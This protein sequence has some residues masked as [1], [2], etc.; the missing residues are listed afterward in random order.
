MPRTALSLPTGSSPT[1]YGHAGAAR[2]VNMFAEKI[3]PQAKTQTAWWACD[4]LSSFATLTGGGGVRA[5]LALSDSALYVIA[6][7]LVF[8]VDSAGAVTVIGGI[9]TDGFVTMARNRVGQIAIVCDGLYFVIEDEDLTQISDPDLPPPTSVTH[10][11]GYFVYLLEDGRF[12]AS[13]IDATGVDALDTATAEANP[14]GG[15]RAMTRGRDLVLFG[16]RSTEFWGNTGAEFP[17]S[18]TT[19]NDLGCLAAGSVA[20][21]EQTLFWVCHDGTVR[22]LDGYQGRKISSHAVERFI[23]S[24]TDPSALRAT[25]WQSRGH[26]FYALSGAAGTWQYDV[27]TGEWVERQSYGLDRWRVSETIQFGHR[28]IAGN[29]ASGLLYTMS[30]DVYSEA[31]ADMV[32]TIQV[33]PVY[34]DG[35]RVRHNRVEI[36][37][38]PGTGLVLPETT[39]TSTASIYWWL[40]FWRTAETVSAADYRHLIRPK[41]MLDY[42]DDGGATWSTQRALEMGAAGQRLRRCFAHRLGVSRSRTYRMSISASVARGVVAMTLDQDVLGN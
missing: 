6:G 29:Y 11:D 8:L 35:R 5:M 25:A 17:F 18:R 4:G 3:G 34:A 36:D 42:S 10:I 12:F 15:V 27:T 33:P 40:P 38:V 37:V 41:L 21:L 26:S 13:G 7:R 32:C 20:E 23:A 39:T 22:V 16:K 24:E 14:D 31:G 28:I 2:I 19:A 1:R 9:P 30:P